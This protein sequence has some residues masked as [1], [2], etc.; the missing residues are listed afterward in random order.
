MTAGLL[1]GG[2]KA[3]LGSPSQ[4]GGAGPGNAGAPFG[5]MIES[6]GSLLQVD[7]ACLARN[8]IT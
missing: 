7:L 6:L 4:E 8:W 5:I 1:L 3:R 2:A